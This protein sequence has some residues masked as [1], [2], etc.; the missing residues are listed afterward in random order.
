MFI[1]TFE[2]DPYSMSHMAVSSIV[3]PGD[4]IEEIRGAVRAYYELPDPKSQVASEYQAA[5]KEPLSSLDKE[6]CMKALE[7]SGLMEDGV[8]SDVIMM[9]C[10]I[11]REPNMEYAFADADISETF[12]QVREA[13][14]RYYEAD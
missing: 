2:D 7:D 14:K 8:N 10:D 5:G 12:E 6:S 4:L 9:A 13:V 11:E 1:E 3:L